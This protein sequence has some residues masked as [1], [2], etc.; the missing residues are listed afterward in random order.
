[1]TQ[2]GEIAVL[3]IGK[4]NVDLWVAAADGTLFRKR[5]TP[6]RVLAG[7]P[8]QHHD[9]DALS[10]WVGE[11]LAYFC[12]E[13][14]IR[15]VV[16][17]GHGSGGVLTGDNPDANGAGLAMPMIDYEQPCPPEID[18]E[19][20]LKA[21]SFQDR[22]SPVMMASTHAARQLLWMEY[23]QPESFKAARHYLNVAQYW[24]WW[25]TGVAASEYSAMGAQSHL[26][27]VR[28]RRWTPIVEGQDWQRLMPEFRPAWTALGTIRQPLVRKFDLPDDITV[29]TGAH[30]STANFYRYIAEGMCDFT[31]ISTGTWIVGLSLDV[32][33]SSLD[34]ARSMTINSDLDG[35]AVGGALVMGGR[36]FSSIAGKDWS[37]G[38]ADAEVLARLVARKTLAIPSFSNNEGQFPGSGC[39]GHFLGPPPK[40]QKE[41]TALALLYT[42]I[43]TTTCADVLNGGETLVLDGT[44]LKEP[45]FAPL[46]AALRGTRET[47]LSDEPHG[48]VTGAVRLA[49]HEVRKNPRCVSV[50]PVKPLAIPGLAAYFQSWRRVADEK[51]KAEND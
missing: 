45:L 30:D 7:P 12:R 18:A 44:F 19:Y 33:L 34:E 36:E 49:D 20:S 22:G 17:V 2:T 10:V 38:S 42:A 16:P 4:T 37:G 47:V 46:V 9:V 40:D 5:S 51:G 23:A 28:Q 41:R 13:H 21:G 43:L 24:G 25:L 35:N 3:D 48:V 6:N 31:L 50:E 8:W 15:V 11:T 27:N 1:M 26:W 32:D 14:P 39:R 29:L